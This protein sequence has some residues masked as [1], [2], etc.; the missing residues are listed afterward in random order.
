MTVNRMQRTLVGPLYGYRKAVR[1]F[2][3][4]FEPEDRVRRV[5][6]HGRESFVVEGR[7]CSGAIVI[8][9]GRATRL[10]LTSNKKGRA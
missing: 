1:A 10:S 8:E 6:G 3:A 4:L 7:L 9:Q 2:L 5:H